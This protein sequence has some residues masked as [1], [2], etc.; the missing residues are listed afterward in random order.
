MLSWV[1]RDLTIEW[2]LKAESVKFNGRVPQLQGSTN[3][4][5]SPDVAIRG[6]AGSATDRHLQMV[7]IIVVA[8]DSF[9]LNRVATNTH[10]R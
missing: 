6:G 8:G 5:H 3:D 2:V 10:G 7:I 4:Q 9:K 1:P